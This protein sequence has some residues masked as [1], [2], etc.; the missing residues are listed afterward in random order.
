MIGKPAAK[1]R[2]R[3]RTRP[4]NRRSENVSVVPP[5]HINLDVLPFNGQKIEP[6]LGGEENPGN[7][8][9]VHSAL[10][11]E[12]EERAAPRAFKE[13]QERAPDDSIG[14]GGHDA[15]DQLR[16]DALGGHAPPKRAGQTS[17]EREGERR[18]AEKLRARGVG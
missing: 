8:H 6:A 15:D 17:D 5:T 14:D 9:R 12:N 13:R 4:R 7:E 18:H 11:K 2:L 16:R 10:K 3:P 1:K